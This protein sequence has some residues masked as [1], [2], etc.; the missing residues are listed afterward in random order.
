MATTATLQV[1]FPEVC[2]S[3]IIVATRVSQA[4]CLE[5]PLRGTTRYTK[6]NLIACMWHIK[7]NILGGC[8]PGGTGCG[9]KRSVE[10]HIKTRDFQQHFKL[11]FES[12]FK[13]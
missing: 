2:W 8:C 7:R 12:V 5:N 3:N 4:L 10:T 13:W 1:T 6:L 11:I 9:A